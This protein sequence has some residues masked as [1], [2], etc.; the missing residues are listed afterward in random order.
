LL[1]CGARWHGFLRRTPLAI[2]VLDVPFLF[3]TVRT[4][5]EVSN[6]PQ[7]SAAVAFGSF[8][9]LI[10]LAV[11]S[12]DRIT[13]V[14]TA[15]VA[16]TAHYFILSKAGLDGA[17]WLASSFVILFLVTAVMVLA[18]ARIQGLVRDVTAEQA[19]RAKLN[20][21]FSPLVA[22]RIAAEGGA[23]ATGQHREVSILMS[24]IRGFT[25]MAESMESPAVVAMLNEYLTLMVDVIFRHGG[26][27]DKFIG[28][29][30]LA[31]FGAPLEQPDH[32]ARAVGCALDM[33]AALEGLNARRAQRG[34]APLT[35]G[36]GVHTGRVVVGDVGSELR[37]DYTVIGDAVNLASRI[38]G[39]TKLQRVPVLAS[40]Q[41]RAHADAGGER[42]AWQPAD[43]MT[44]KGQSK[45]VVTFIPTRTLPT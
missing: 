30:I 14:L 22:E 10:V 41:A 25:A 15:A 11:L 39:L 8:L 37:R 34:E 5:L 33:V 36:V 45:P 23:A 7:A 24:D 3:I 2:A 13:I 43:P 6:N 19:M 9:F 29:G 21:Y 16:A 38:E 1:I 40:E 31:Y 4:G 32:A 26:T 28:D 12:L 42:F 20:R 27:L 17:M 44:V 18:T 35:I